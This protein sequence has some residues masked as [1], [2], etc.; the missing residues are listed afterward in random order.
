MY[1]KNMGHLVRVSVIYGAVI[2]ILG[3]IAGCGEESSNSPPVINSF[4]ASSTDVVTNSEV[5]LTVSAT[6][7]DGD[8]LTYT[9]Q[10][11]GGTISGT[12]NVVT[13]IAPATA[14]NY[15][16]TVDISDGELN[17]QDIVTITVVTPET[18]P[19]SLEGMVFIPAGEFE[20]GDSLDRITWAL[21]VH[22]VY[23]DAFYMDIY[24]V[25]NAQYQKFMEA[26]GR[27]AHRHLSDPK[28]RAPEQPV[29]GVSW[30]D[31][32][33]YAE[34]AGK[35]LPTEAQWEKAARG[36]LAGKRYSWGDEAPDAGGIYRA[37]Y[38]Q[39]DY[40]ADGYYY[41]APVGSFA[42]N[43]YGLYDMAGN[44]WEWCADWYLGYYYEYSPYYN[45]LGPNGGTYRVVRGGAWRNDTDMWM[46]PWGS[47][48]DMLRVAD[49]NY[50]SPAT[51]PYRVG[52]RCI[53]QY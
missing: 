26:T 24:E 34:W 52:L 10:S 27:A 32:V 40:A 47:D 30:H 4:E 41:T 8:D 15:T 16:I 1:M 28:Y 53:F 23:L 42:P 17:V 3:L 19:V 21:P 22:T 50:G 5:I 18:P 11:T 33:A 14:G 12:G 35:Q 38:D 43:G 45:P 6:D 51:T 7:D 37:N 36:G 31:A 46:W 13:W 49:R 48:T 39:D 29:V 20:M 2:V 9:Y 44:V 25:T